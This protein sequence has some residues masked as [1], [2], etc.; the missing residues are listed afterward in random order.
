MLVVE[1][2]RF[3]TAR[4]AEEHVSERR[5]RGRFL[6][7]GGTDRFRFLDRTA[8]LD[9][10]LLGLFQEGKLDVAAE[11]REIVEKVGSAVGMEERETGEG[12]G[13]RRSLEERTSA[14]VVL[15]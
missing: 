1:E 2:G 6:T 4:P 9:D 15:S 13:G 10:L 3:D 7:L 5:K 12:G 11:D 8:L 14:T